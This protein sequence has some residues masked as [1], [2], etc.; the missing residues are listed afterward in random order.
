MHV[1]TSPKPF[2]QAP[3]PAA[4][5]L[6]DIGTYHISDE[7]WDEVVGEGVDAEPLAS[8]FAPQISPLPAV[9]QRRE[10]DPLVEPMLCSLEDGGVVERVVGDPG[11]PATCWPFVP[12]T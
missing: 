12:K 4:R 8:E 9:L 3:D 7:L 11:Q 10:T 5:G 6:G 2:L 1:S